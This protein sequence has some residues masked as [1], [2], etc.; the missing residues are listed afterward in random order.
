MTWFIKAPMIIALLGVIGFAGMYAIFN[1]G[2]LMQQREDASLRFA[3]E[4]LSL[5]GKKWRA[6]VARLLGAVIMIFG[7]VGAAG[8]YEI[9]YSDAARDNPL[10]QDDPV[11]QLARSLE[12]KPGTADN[13]GSAP[14]AAS[15]PALDPLGR[16]AAPARNFPVGTPRAKSA[17]EIALDNHAAGINQMMSQ[18]D[19]GMAIQPMPPIDPKLVVTPVPQIVSG[20]A[21]APDLIDQHLNVARARWAEGDLSGAVRAAENAHAAARDFLGSEHP[22]TQAVGAMV[23]EARKQEGASAGQVASP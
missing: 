9:F 10:V 5:L 13:G 7:F 21:A 19:G 14:G 11:F 3:T 20:P 18:L 8:V 22:R 16:P 2:F 15:A 17:Q 1:P 6:P 4:F 12:E 23:D